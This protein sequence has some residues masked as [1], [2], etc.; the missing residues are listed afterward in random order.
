MQWLPAAALVLTLVTSLGWP[1]PVSSNKEESQ[2]RPPQPNG[3]SEDAGDSGNLE[4]LAKR[5]QGLEYGRYLQQVVQAL[6]QDEEFAKKLENIPADQIRSGDVAKALDFV[7]HGVRTQLDELKRI[8]IERLRS[9]TREALEGGAGYHGREGARRWRTIPMKEEGHLPRHLNARNPHT[10]E[11]DDLKKLIQA[12][13]FVTCFFFCLSL[14][15][16]VQAMIIMANRDLE[17]LD[18]KRKEEFKKYEMEKEYAY[19]AN[20]ANMTEEERKESQRKHEELARRHRDHPAINHPGGKQQLEQVWEE[21]DRMPKEEF[22][23]QL[24]FAMHDT[25]QDGFLD[26]QEVEALLTL[27]VKKLYDPAHNPEEDDPV[28]MME[29]YNRMREHIYSEADKNKDR[30]ISKEE[31]VDMTKRDEFTRDEGWKDLDEQPV[32][33]EKEFKEYVKAKEASHKNSE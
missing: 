24:F 7:Q 3:Q 21:Q 15:H 8:E 4:S 26:E 25:N 29:E 14:V 16:V 1:S 28:E 30:L 9:L 20:L 5:V 32:F 12:V 23:P 31:F 18:K 27:E 2:G 19:R 33:S 10:F 6:E 13:S 22:S 17:E 11:V